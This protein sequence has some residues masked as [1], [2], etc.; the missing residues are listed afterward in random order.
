MTPLISEVTSRQSPKPIGENIGAMKPA[1]T[2][3]MLPCESSTMSRE[4][5][6]CC[7]NHST[8]VAMKMIVKARCKKS[9]AFSHS[10]RI[11][12]FVPGIR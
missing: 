2:E 4:K 1:I 7:R 12:F 3:S 8:M 10:R 11:T 6:K 5:L 9:F